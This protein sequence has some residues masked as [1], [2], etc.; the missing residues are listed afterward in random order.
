MKCNFHWLT[1][2][3]NDGNSKIKHIKQ[4]DH[5]ERQTKGNFE[6]WRKSFGAS[7]ASEK[8]YIPS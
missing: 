3:Q 1:K 2:V 5:R 4:I 8:I 7:P 6:K